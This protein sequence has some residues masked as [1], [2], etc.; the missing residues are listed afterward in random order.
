MKNLFTKYGLMLLSL[1][2][3]IAVLLSLM[4]YFSTSSAPLP[5][6]AG[7][8]ASPFRAVA[9]AVTRTVDGWQSYFTDF[10]RLKEENE[11]LKLQIAE[12]EETIRQAEYDRDEN[13]RLRE[14]AELRSSAGTSNLNPPVW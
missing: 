11:A 6:L 8:V 1:A 3:A 12:M 2:V 9:A 5:D 14:L 7:I 13:Q 4:T 10:D